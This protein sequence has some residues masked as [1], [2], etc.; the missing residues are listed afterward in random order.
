MK[1]KQGLINEDLQAQINIY[2]ETKLEYIYSQY[3]TCLLDKGREGCLFSFPLRA[4]F[5]VAFL[6]AS[7]FSKCC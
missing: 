5:T 6:Y 2:F 3:K 4:G 7:R 1:L